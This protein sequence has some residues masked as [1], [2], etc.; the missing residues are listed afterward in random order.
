MARFTS[1]SVLPNL[2]QRPVGG[3][4]I[5]WAV[6]DLTFTPAFQV[7]MSETESGPWTDQLD[8]KAANTSV[9]GVGYQVQSQQANFWFRVQ[10]FDGAALR[11]TSPAMDQR[12]AMGDRDY[13]RY[14]EIL[15]RKRLF[16]NKTPT[17]P[18]WLLR[19]RIVG[20]ICTDCCDES[21]QT[22]ASS[23][24]GSCYGTGIVSGYYPEVAM[25]ADWFSGSVPRNNNQTVKMP[26]GPT[27][28]Q[29]AKINI[30]A[31]PD[32]RSEDVWV[33]KGTRY[34]FL[35]EKCEPEHWG[36]SVIGQTLDLSRLPTQHPV[37]RMPIFLTNG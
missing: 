17:L 18:G 3:F 28:V 16:L 20:A 8:P 31:L 15:R 14:R 6:A 22:P 35:V 25:R 4:D 24:C 30:F 36:G 2:G 21:I 13:L 34:A 1:I 33:D 27:Q 19:R 32:A 10:M 37:Y 11:A 29:K 7:Q 5:Y 9:I 26:A 23:E 12:N